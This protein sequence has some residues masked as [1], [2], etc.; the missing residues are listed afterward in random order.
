MTGRGGPRDGA[1]PRVVA[2]V[3]AWNR[4]DLLLRN[5]DG[6]AAQ[7]RPVDGVVVIDNASTDDS[8]EVAER[9]EAVT[10]V[11]RMPENLGG[12]GG[13]AAGIAR[14]VV[15]HGADLVWI[16]DDDTVPT[17]DALEALLTA[18]ASY[19][20]RVALLASRADWTDG[21]EHPMNTPRE[22][23]GITPANRARAE[24]VGAR[25][26]RSASFVSILVDADVI[27]AEGL[28]VADY[29]L[30]N[31]DFEF[32]A[33]IL[34]DRVGLYVPASRVLHATK[35]FGSSDVD[36]GPRFFN[37]TR[38]KVWL[39]TRADALGVRDTA[40]YGASTLLRWGRMLARSADRGT[41]LR[42]GLDGLRAGVRAP[43]TTAEVLAGTPVAD[44]VRALGSPTPPRTADPVPFSV[45]LPVYR[46]DSAVF[47]RRAVTSVTADQ[48]LRPAEL[49]V[50]RDGP[51]GP[52]LEAVLDELRSGGLTAGVPVQ[53]VELESNVGLALALE[54]GLARCAHEVV[55]RADADDVSVPAR[56]AAQLPLF[57]GQ[58]LD[59]MS[60]AIVEFEDDE[61]R[62]GAMRV[63]PSDPDEIARL[64]RLQ[65]PFNHPAVVYR[66]T[67]VREAGGYRH[68][69][70]MEDYWLF[71]RMIEAGARVGNVA[72][73]L[74]LYRVGA[75]AYDR[76]GGLGM[77][78]SEFA[79]QRHLRAEGF[80]S[81]GQFGRNLAVR[82]VWR[83]VPA[84]VRRPAYRA[85]AA[86]RLRRQ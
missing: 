28:P 19:D 27:R 55:A 80:T 81:W 61:A 18:R 31:D 59:L 15:R 72:E 34:R 49:V 38:N 48:E 35:K 3:V 1:A 82:G 58:D 64:A 70:K 37:E 60:A 44:D 2:V 69:D 52:E 30:W 51:V 67:A 6:L 9:H 41:L 43:R 39:F 56:F 25:E 57:V 40:L 68:L 20:G 17:P 71:A 29:F 53:V 76:R 83:V 78:R 63:W 73:P 74:V 11:V 4:C 54:A 24:A 46:G 16:M 5:L 79:L 8:A 75:G 42:H 65:D 14:A 32:T 33:R 22:R 62:T 86:A 26:I 21:R 77:L 47:F 84:A 50:V 23:F 85:R 66:K 45:L 36:P 13:F 10:E 12:A 7:A